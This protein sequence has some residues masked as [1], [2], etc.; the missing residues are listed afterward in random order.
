ML[1][2]P[3][4]WPFLFLHFHWVGRAVAI[5]PTNFNVLFLLAAPLVFGKW[6]EKPLFLR[7]ALWIAVPLSAGALCF[8]HFDEIRDY[9][10]VYPIVVWLGTHGLLTVFR[11]VLDW[12]PGETA[13][14]EASC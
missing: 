13:G 14:G 11:P 7:R 2:D 10:E 8:G 1:G 5:Y 4:R 9:Y 6:R 3:G 12:R